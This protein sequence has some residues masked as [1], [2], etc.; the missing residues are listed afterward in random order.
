MVFGYFDT[1]TVIVVILTIIL[2][3]RVQYHDNDL[4]TETFSCTLVTFRSTFE[5][6]TGNPPMWH[7]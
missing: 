5:T 2:L 6:K 7:L 3:P 4:R 1:L